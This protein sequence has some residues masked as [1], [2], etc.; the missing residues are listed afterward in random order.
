MVETV[1]DF[2]DNLK[3]DLQEEY[4]QAEK[5]YGITQPRLSRA[6]D[7]LLEKGFITCK[8]QGGGYKQDKSLYALSENWRLWKTGMIFE[9]RKKDTVQ[10]GFRKPKRESRRM[11]A[12]V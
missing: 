5:K 8:Y 12:V 9:Q 4:R 6:F 11:H 2:W 10:R 3:P 7:Q 1:F